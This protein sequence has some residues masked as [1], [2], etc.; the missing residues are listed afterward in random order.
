MGISNNKVPYQCHS[1]YFTLIEA[2]LPIIEYDVSGSTPKGGVKEHRISSIYALNF[3]AKSILSDRAW[4]N[5]ESLSIFFCVFL[6]FGYKITEKP[7]NPS[8]NLVHASTLLFCG[9]HR[10]HQIFRYCSVYKWST[11][12]HM[13]TQFSVDIYIRISTSPGNLPK[14]PKGQ[15]RYADWN[16]G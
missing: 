1:L 10:P 6:C 5:L 2:L 3:E 15:R 8:D 7:W 16:L 9:W 14:S 13:P 11:L 12:C 4:V